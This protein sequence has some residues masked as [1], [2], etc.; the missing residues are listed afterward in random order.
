MVFV[1]W[2]LIIDPIPFA[3]MIW[4]VFIADMCYTLAN[5]LLTC[6]PGLIWLVFGLFWTLG[7][8]VQFLEVEGPTCKNKLDTK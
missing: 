4:L 2:L 6:V 8:F 7:T 1:M 3:L 5:S